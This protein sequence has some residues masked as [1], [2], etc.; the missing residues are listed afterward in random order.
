MNANTTT[1]SLRCPRRQH[2]TAQ[3]LEKAYR[4]RVVCD[5]PFSLPRMGKIK[6]QCGFFGLVIQE[7]I[8]DEL[9]QWLIQNLQQIATS[10]TATTTL[11][12]TFVRYVLFFFLLL[13]NV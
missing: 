3:I 12:L 10:T 6:I 13:L 11:K 8:R 2:V 5:V 4:Q 1:S 9:Y 7:D